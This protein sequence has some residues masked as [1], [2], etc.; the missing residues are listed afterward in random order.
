MT[1]PLFDVAKEG[2]VLR[3]RVQ[4]GAGS[5]AVVGLHGDALKVRV[6]AP[7]VSGRANDALLELLARALGVPVSALT[8][9]AGVTG[10]D[11][12]VLVT[13]LDDVELARRLEVAVSGDAPGARSRGAR[14]ARRGGRPGPRGG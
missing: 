2:L 8:V 12:R 9:S 10:R 7:P 14:T 5:S 4:P 1:R 3:V 6:A 11:K 13:G